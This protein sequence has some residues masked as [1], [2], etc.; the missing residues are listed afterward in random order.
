M[1]LIPRQTKVKVQFF[2]NFSIMDAVIA[3]I[4]VAVIALILATSLSF[5]LILAAVALMFFVVLY[6]KVAPETRLYQSFGD[7]VK[8]LFGVRTFRKD[9]NNK[10]KGVYG[11][12]PYVGVTEDGLIDYKDYSQV[13]SLLQKFTNNLK[14]QNPNLRYLIVPELHPNTGGIHFHGLL[15]DCPNLKLVEAKSPRTGKPIYKVKDIMG[16]IGNLSDMLDKYKALELQVKK[17]QQG[18]KEDIM[19]D[20]RSGTFDD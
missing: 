9:P 7:M 4:G 14:H 12:T 10:H 5:K 19:G 11:I 17:E 8:F 6:I 15:A 13:S 3:F 2:K 20:A 18:G 1:R 16:E